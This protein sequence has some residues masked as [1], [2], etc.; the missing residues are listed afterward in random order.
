[1]N[2]RNINIKSL[3]RPIVKTKMRPKFAMIRFIWISP[4]DTLKDSF[5]S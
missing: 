5:F 3:S 4:F 1:M 2:F